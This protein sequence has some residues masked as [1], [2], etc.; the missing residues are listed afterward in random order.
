MRCLI[1]NERGFKNKY[2]K[3]LVLDFKINK[4]LVIYGIK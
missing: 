3:I 4:V 1:K 2:M